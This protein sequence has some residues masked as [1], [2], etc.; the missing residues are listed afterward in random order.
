MF[1]SSST[2]NTRSDCVGMAPIWSCPR[3]DGF[4]L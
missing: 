4:Q 2:I 3:R 1:F